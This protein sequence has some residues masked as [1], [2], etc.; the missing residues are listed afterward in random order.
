MAIVR[1]DTCGL[2]FRR[3]KRA[4]HDAPVKPVGFPNTGVI[5][6]ITNCRNPGMVWLQ[7]DEYDEY[8]RGEGYFS[9][10]TNSIKVKVE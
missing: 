2:D 4:Y 6:G 10:K 8:L 9:V 7:K 3:T 5:C 1:C